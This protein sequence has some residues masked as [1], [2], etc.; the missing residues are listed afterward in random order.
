[1]ANSFNPEMLV[2]ARESR[3]LT[4]GVLADR[5]NVEQGTLSKFEAGLLPVSDD[6]LVRISGVLRYPASFFLNTERVYGFNSSVFFHR[7]RAAI[8]DRTLRAIHAQINIRRFNIKRLLRAA[9]LDSPYKFYPLDISEF[10]GKPERVAQMVRGMWHIPPGPIHNVMRLI[11]DAGGLAVKLDFG[12]RQIDAISEWVP[13]SVPLFFINASSEITGDRLRLTLA[14]EIGHIFMHQVPNEY[15]EKQA[16]LFAAEL[17][18]PAREIKSSLYKLTLARLANLKSE[19][20]VSM[21]A[22]VERA[23]ELKTITESQRKYLYIHLSRRGYRIR[24]PEETDIPIESPSLLGR[25]IDAHLGP[26]GYSGAELSSFVNLD[27]EEFNDIYQRSGKLRL[28][29]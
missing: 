29:G 17:L 10:Q 28:I 16:N 27:Q 4:Q 11:E 12:T 21:A 23:Y 7:K 19:W 26:L 9:Q 3:G 14:H 24:E 2:L 6:M 18:M 1:M 25:M 8:P 13:D 20:R 22:L 15:M 5:L